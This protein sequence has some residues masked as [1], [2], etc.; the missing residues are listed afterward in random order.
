MFCENGNLT[1]LLNY[2]IS[3]ILRNIL[4]HSGSSESWICAQKWHH[5]DYVE[6]EVVI[7]DYGKGIINKIK[8]SY[9]R[10]KS[11]ELFRKILSPGFTHSHY[12]IRS[13]EDEGF[14][15]SGYGLYVVSNICKN[16]N[17]AFKVLSN[18]SS[19]YLNSC[20]NNYHDLDFN[21]PGTPIKMKFQIPNN[22]DTDKLS[23]H[24]VKEGEDIV[25]QDKDTVNVA[26]KRAK[27][28]EI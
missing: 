6:V 2:S 14:Q 22:L 9:P 1:K 21:F 15:N 18:T 25:G 8:D 23:L 19:Y 13:Y 4:E 7:V 24:I 3:E 5:Q 16:L 28:L 26:S 11:E 17:G 20:K 27:S 12:E 10:L